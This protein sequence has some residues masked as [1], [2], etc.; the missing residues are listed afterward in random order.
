MHRHEAEGIAF[1]QIHG[2]EFG[3]ADARRVLQHGVE[4]RLEFARRTA[5]DL[6]HLDGRRLLLQRLGQLPRA[7]LPA[8][9][10]RTF[11]IA[12]TAWS[13]KVSPARSA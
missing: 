3:L 7:C 4:N 10:S 1:T 13:A 8:S 11:S 2:A 5:D 12:I 6:E 9:N